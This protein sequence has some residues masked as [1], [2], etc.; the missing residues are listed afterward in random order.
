MAW[1]MRKSGLN[2]G[3]IILGLCLM[4]SEPVILRIQR[5]QPLLRDPLMIFDF[6]F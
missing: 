5:L 4:D 3:Q 2:D 6:W 1:M